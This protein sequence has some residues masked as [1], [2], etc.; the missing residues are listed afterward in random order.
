MGFDITRAV[1]DTLGARTPLTD[2]LL[3][4]MYFADFLVA[5][6]STWDEYGSGV[7]LIGTKGDGVQ[8]HGL[9]LAGPL[10]ENRTLPATS[11]SPL[12]SDKARDQARV[13]DLLAR[14]WAVSNLDATS[15]RQPIH[16]VAYRPDPVALGLRSVVES[17]GIGGGGCIGYAPVGTESFQAGS[18]LFLLHVLFEVGPRRP[19]R[20]PAR[21]IVTVIA[22]RGPFEE[23]AGGFL[24]ATLR[25]LST[26][27]NDGIIEILD[28]HPAYGSDLASPGT[29]RFDLGLFD[30]STALPRGWTVTGSPPSV[31]RLGSWSIVLDGIRERL[32]AI[33]AAVGRAWKGR[34]E[35]IETVRLL[36]IDGPPHAVQLL[37]AG[38]LPPATTPSQAADLLM[39]F[40]TP[41]GAGVGDGQDVLQF[42]P[43]IGGNR[44]C[45][46][47]PFP[48]SSL[49]TTSA[50]RIV[51]GPTPA[52]A[53]ADPAGTARRYADLYSAR[54]RRLL[55]RRT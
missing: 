27:T 33:G 40:A 52:E 11:G 38:A 24:A 53:A 46:P 8:D 17:L 19:P 7:T 2:R 44:A 21:D 36:A 22:D 16:L 14:I 55:A 23:P 26:L 34:A 39:P 37:V 51:M 6:Q 47:T 3:S 43:G 54:L 50:D 1:G 18:S 15:L 29:L 9:L 31:E 10:P 4:Y 12:S 30:T 13:V 5:E 48:V 41:G 49:A 35:G 20:R 42:L 32:D 45:V 28:L 25:T